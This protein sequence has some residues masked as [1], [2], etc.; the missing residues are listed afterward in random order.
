M[1]ILVSVTIDNNNNNKKAR[2]KVQKFTWST[3]MIG[4]KNFL[5]ALGFG[6]SINFWSTKMDLLPPKMTSV[7]VCTTCGIQAVPFGRTYKQRTIHKPWNN[8]YLCFT[9]GLSMTR[10][11]KN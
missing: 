7:I 8:I 4:I 5:L 6:P 1:K 11:K 2:I 10:G 9:E 3:K